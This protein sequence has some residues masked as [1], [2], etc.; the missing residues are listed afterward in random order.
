MARVLMVASEATPFAKTGGVAEVVGSL[1]CALQ[2]I[3]DEVAVVLP[4]YRGVTVADRQVD[5]RRV[6]LGPRTFEVAV[7]QTSHDK[8]RY[9]FIDCPPLYDRPGLYGEAQD[10]ADNPL[11]FALLCRMALEIARSVWP[12]QVLHCHDWQTGL[13]PVYLHTESAP[14]AAAGVVK[15]VFTIHNLAYQGR[16]G[17]EWLPPL[18]LPTHLLAPDKLEYWGDISLL[19][20]GVNYADMLTTISP[21]YAKEIQTPDFG[22]GFDGVLR[23]RSGDLVGILNGIDAHYWNPAHD[24]HLP[25][26]YDA[27]SNAGKAAAKQALLEAYGIQPTDAAMERP[28]VGMVSR[29]VDQKGFD[30]FLPIRDTL[31]RLDASFVVL[32]TGDP[33]HEEFWRV[34][35]ARHPDRIG[36]RIG[37]DEPLAHL[38]FGGA[39]LF[40]MPSRYEPCGLNQFYSLRYGTV[41]VVRATGGLADSVDD[42]VGFRF[43]EYSPAALLDTLQTAMEVYRSDKRRWAALMRNGMTRDHSWLHV[44]AKYS[45]L[46]SQLVS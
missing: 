29:L 42:E 23:Q 41:P 35:A 37:F 17:P 33:R 12:A 9:Y 6:V 24:P 40:L 43:F 27:T 34:V 5:S 20:A 46:Y 39:D 2:A 15:S 14:H 7:F 38:V 31:P 28:L 10:Y 18:G 32:G 16:F 4:R 13:A 26:L 11:R 19:K 1:S 25:Q 22:F 45:K 3:G 21:G 8:V 30:L 44:A 36:A